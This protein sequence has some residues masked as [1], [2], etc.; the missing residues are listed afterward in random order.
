MFLL[1]CAFQST[2]PVWAATVGHSAHDR[3]HIVSIHAARVGR[4]T[5]TPKYP[6]IITCFNPRGPCGPRRQDATRRRAI[7]NVSIHAARVGRDDRPDAEAAQLVAFQSTRPVWAATRYPARCDIAANVSIHA[8]RVGRDASPAIIA[9][10]SASFNPRGPCGPRP[11]GRQ[12]VA[13]EE[14]FQSTRPVWAATPIG[15]VSPSARRVSIHAARVGRDSPRHPGPL[16]RCEFQSTRPVWAATPRSSCLS[17]HSQSFNPRGPCGPRRDTIPPRRQSTGFN[18]RGPCG[19]RRERS[20][21]RKPEDS[22]QSTR[23]VWAATSR[24]S[25]ARRPWPRFN[26]RGPCGPRPREPAHMRCASTFQSTRPVW[27]ATA[28]RSRIAV[29]VRRFNPRGPCGPRP[30]TTCA[31]WRH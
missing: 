14:R 27:A 16:R 20:K 8:A 22:F 23:P 30:R 24:P 6:G 31:R 3:A 19:P 10:I 25:M 4:D 7:A 1:G 29:A 2:R 5:N 15:R 9:W 21:P 11:Q 12:A 13:G 28:R 18:P 26:P 17:P